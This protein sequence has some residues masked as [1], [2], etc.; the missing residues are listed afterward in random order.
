MFKAEYG[1]FGITDGGIAVRA[2]TDRYEDIK[3]SN[4]RTFQKAAVLELFKET[5]VSC[6]IL[7]EIIQKTTS[8]AISGRLLS[9]SVPA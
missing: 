5:A 6:C 8:S 7:Y 1:R 2:V 9:A 4:G 3:P